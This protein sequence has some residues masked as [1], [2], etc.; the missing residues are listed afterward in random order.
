[1]YIHLD[2]ADYFVDRTPRPSIDEMIEIL[3][4]KPPL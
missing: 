4:D 3:A 2:S 1:M